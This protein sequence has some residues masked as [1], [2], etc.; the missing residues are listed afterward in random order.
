MLQQVRRAVILVLI[1]A[2]MVQLTGCKEKDPEPSEEE[3]V[4]GKL[5]S[6]TW[7]VQG[8]TVDDVDQTPVYK[9][10][11]ITFTATTYTTTK[12][13]PVWPASGTWSFTD[14][15]AS[16]I[17]REDGTEIKIE[18]ATETSLKLSLT[19]SKTTLGSGRMESVKGLH[20]FTFRK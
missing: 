13:G 14:D 11:T 15:T 1:A 10:L 20:V 19:W 7:T 6:G 12:G 9:G 3:I 4:K 8:V 2:S 16:S 17:K 18:E 5:T